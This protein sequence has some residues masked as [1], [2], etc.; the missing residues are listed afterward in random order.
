MAQAMLVQAWMLFTGQPEEQAAQSGEGLVRGEH[1]QDG[2][3]GAAW[4][5]PGETGFCRLTRFNA[6]PPSQALPL[7]RACGRVSASVSKD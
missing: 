2:R 6:D 4:R 1:R 3:R 5:S 7:R